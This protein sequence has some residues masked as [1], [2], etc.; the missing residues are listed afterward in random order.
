M[1]V[2]TLPPPTDCK[3][4][5]QQGKTKTALKEDGSPSQIFKPIGTQNKCW[6]P[7][8]SPMCVLPTQASVLQ[9]LLQ[10]GALPWVQ[11]S[12]QEPAPEKA[13]DGITCAFGYPPALT[14][15]P[16]WAAG[17][18]LLHNGLFHESES[19]RLRFALEF[20]PIQYG[21]TGAQQCPGHPPAQALCHGCLQS[22][23][24]HNTLR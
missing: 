15:D 19:L 22:V 18:S 3:I 16:P 21:S 13:F 2:H 10:S 17:G 5:F 20:Q 8:T 1:A 6:L 24:R 14:W 11:R 23:P 9:E 7:S 4:L 12:C